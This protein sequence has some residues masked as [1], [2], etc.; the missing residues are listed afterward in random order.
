[1]N[2]YNVTYSKPVLEKK[3]MFKDLERLAQEIYDSG[4]VRIAKNN[5]YNFIK[6]SIVEDD[7]H[8]SFSKR[9]IT[10]S[11]LRN[12]VERFVAEALKFANSRTYNKAE[13]AKAMAY[14][15]GQA[16]LLSDIEKEEEMRLCRLIVQSA[17]P[18][19]I[20]M[21]I[22]Y[23]V[24]IFISYSFKIG[25]LLDI[26]SQ[27]T[28]GANNGMQSY[29]GLGAGYAVYVS[30]GGNPFASGDSKTY[31]SDGSEA[32]SR[33]MIV[34]AQEMGH[35]ADMIRND[36]YQYIGRHSADA[37]G[38]A[39]KE[40]VRKARLLDINVCLKR[41]E[42]LQK[43]GINN[44]MHIEKATRFYAENRK[45][46]LTLLFSRLKKR[47][48]MRFLISAVSS[49]GVKNS[50][51]KDKKNYSPATMLFNAYEDTLFNLS[52]QADAYER[53]NSEAQEAI[54]C[55]EA[56]ARVPQQVVKW[57]HKFTAQNMPNLYRIY[58]GKVTRNLISEYESITGQK[59]KGVK[60]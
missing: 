25:D 30:A 55:I 42:A 49:A 8:I 20:K 27:N 23:G 38:R 52:P 3:K 5:R 46:S 35:F 14:I 56:L 34:A 53:K 12:K 54:L 29:G 45:G 33:L 43:K 37:S 26:K 6:Y 10:D 24:E 40:D 36:K 18:A 15:D 59:Y 32:M 19:V 28:S 39:P 13:L 11:K 21:M 31:Q 9:E 60:R 48:A 44:V 57:G 47:L 1:M 50:L 58:Y 41:R 2:L 7:V 22:I 4:R 51:Q 16:K 17:H